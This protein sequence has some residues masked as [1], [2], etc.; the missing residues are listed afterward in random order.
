MTRIFLPRGPVDG[1][2]RRALIHF[3]YYRSVSHVTCEP[4]CSVK[5]I[6]ARAIA[7]TPEKRITADRVWTGGQGVMNAHNVWI[8]DHWQS[9]PASCGSYDQS[10]L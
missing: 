4:L 3:A 10:Y 7:K 5:L 9:L 1:V 6:I 8:V 2:P